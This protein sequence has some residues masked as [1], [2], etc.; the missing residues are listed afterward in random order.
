MNSVAEKRQN[1]HLRAKIWIEAGE[2]QKALDHLKQALNEYGPHIGLLADIANCYYN[3]SEMWNFK[4]SLVKLSEEFE[5][6]RP[7]LE[8]NHLVRALI[9]IGKGLEEQAY[10]YLA[11]KKYEEA[12]AHILPEEID[13]LSQ[14]LSQIVRV[15]SYLGQN[16]KVN[17]Y[18]QRLLMMKPSRP[19]LEIEVNHS[20]MLFEIILFGP[21]SA[22]DRFKLLFQNYKIHSIDQKL[23]GFDYLEEALRLGEINPEAQALIESI[24]LEKNDRFEFLMK[25]IWQG[26]SPSVIMG[27]LNQQSHEVTPSSYMRLLFLL[28]HKCSAAAIKIELKKRLLLLLE[29]TDTDTKSLLLKKWDLKL[30]DENLV[31]FLHETHFSVELNG[32]SKSF[33][34]SK[35]SFELLKMLSKQS[36]L[37]LEDVVQKLWQASWN[38]SYYHRVRIMVKRLNDELQSLC[39]IPKCISVTQQKVTLKPN[40]RLQF[41]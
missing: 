19:H 10:F 4:Q 22:Y 13:L 32:N 16:C 6:S 12:L 35:P 34:K 14:C 11:L 33:A 15:K 20:L 40:I 41:K 39:G 24:A 9:F 31:L 30:A 8:R 37:S 3:L 23:I 7:L 18:Y 28:I 38:E 29:Q 27:I 36:D 17:D 21:I 26:K 1:A 2:P 5:I 25:E